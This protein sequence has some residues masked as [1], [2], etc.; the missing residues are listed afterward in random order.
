MTESVELRSTGV[1]EDE[2]LA[3]LRLI[4]QL[5]GDKRRW[6]PGF[7]P[8]AFIDNQ[9]RPHVVDT[10]RGR[11]DRRAYELC[12]AYELRSALR[13]GRV[14]VTGSRRHADPSTLLLPGEQW[15]Q[16]RASFAKAVDQPLDGAERLQALAC[17][18]HELL[19]RLA[20]E[21][22]ATAEGRSMICM[23]AGTN[24]WFHSD[25][26]YR[27]FLALVMMCGC[28]G[29]NGGGWAHY[30]GQEK[31]RPL[32]GWQTLAFALDWVRPP[33]HQSGTPFFY[34]ATDQW[35]Y[36]RIQ[37]EHLA[38]PLGRGLLAGRHIMDV[39]AL[40]ARLGWLPSFPSFDRSTLELVAGG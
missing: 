39:N 3:A 2:L 20:R 38:S 16:S 37:P 7:S 6:L 17:E 29:R 21:Q 31:V 28:E 8:S 1:D 25:Q 30:V 26:V 40:G 9:W 19:E 15:H 35:R 36:E 32:T 14:W 13:A 34:L 33:R 23:G 22:D 4:R 11:F 5:T 12:A 18:Q 10:G 24:H 27:T